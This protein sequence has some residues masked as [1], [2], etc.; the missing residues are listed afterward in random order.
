MAQQRA[1]KRDLVRTLSRALVGAGEI[2]YLPSISAGYYAVRSTRK[3]ISNYNGPAIRVRDASAVETDINF[4]GDEL[5]YVTL[6]AIASPTLRWM[7]D[8]TGNAK[9]I[10]SSVLANQ[11]LV[12]PSSDFNG[13]RALTFDFDPTTSRAIVASSLSVSRPN[14]SHFMV[15]D[16]YLSG[17]ANGYHEFTDAGVATTYDSLYTGTTARLTGNA[18]GSA[19]AADNAVA[20]MPQVL[21]LLSRGSGRVI[22]FQERRKTGAALAAQTMVT[23][24]L[25]ASTFGANF[26]ARGMRVWAD[27][28]IT[29]GISDSDADAVQSALEAI[30]GLKTSFTS[31]IGILGDSIS[32]GW[33]STEL[34]NT[35]HNA[36]WIGS[37]RFFNYGFGGKLLTAMA[38]DYA[39]WVAAQ[40]ESAL[41]TKNILVI[42]GGSNDIAGGAN[43]AT[44]YSGTTTPLIAS[45]KATGYK[46]G[47]ATLLPRTGVDT[48]R[49]AYNSAV[50][51]NAGGADFIVDVGAI[52]GMGAVG[53]LANTTYYNA[54]G[55]HPNDNGHA[56]IQ[57]LYVTA[58]NAQL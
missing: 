13:R 10:G 20:A 36:A 3:L 47:V 57:P 38:T 46:V 28:I 9:Q 25:G 23:Q 29:S 21:A 32:E 1:L 48:Q 51:T 26:R 56:T 19:L 27:I 6:N 50:R 37:P 53:D 22:R 35:F 30:F 39:A 17:N 55:I 44:L 12:R 5:D 4:V 45:A 43:G 24:R 11:P 40:Y 33:Y 14:H 31:T 18:G 54:D 16:P 7:Y 58:I 15:I 42:E 49:L 8:Q 34:R 52:P 2:S 41:G